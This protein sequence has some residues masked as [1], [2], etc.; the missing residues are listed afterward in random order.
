[1]VRPIC[2]IAQETGDVPL[3][4]LFPEPGCQRGCKEDMRVPDAFD[5]ADAEEQGADAF[6]SKAHCPACNST[7]VRWR[8]QGGRWVLFDL[9]PGVEHVCPVEELIK[10]FD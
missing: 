6:E 10:D 9:Q 8:Q 5:Y 4:C 1:M 3:D 2:K 7:D